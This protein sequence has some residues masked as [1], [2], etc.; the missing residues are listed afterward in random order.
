MTNRQRMLAAYRREQP[1]QVPVSPELWYD[2]P[3]EIDPDCTWQD[4]CLGRYPLWRAQ[5]AAHRYFGSAAWL[6]AAPAGQPTR[7]EITST[8][9][10]TPEGDLEVRCSGACGSGA[11]RWRV[12]SNAAFQDWM[13]E[14]PVKDLHRD[15]AAFETLF[16]PDPAAMDMTE[17]KAAL[18]GVGEDGVVTAYAGSLFFSFVAAHLEGGPAAAILAM[19]DNPSFFEGFQRRYVGWIAAVAERIIEECAPEVLMLDNGYSTASIIRPA[20]YEKWDLPVVR[21]VCEAAHGRGGLLHLHQ[22][23]R[24]AA[25]MDMIASAGVDLVDPFERPPSGDTPDLG[26]VKRAYGGRLAIRGNLHAHKTLLRGTPEDVEREVRECIAAAAAGGG[27]ILA[28]GDGV[29]AGTP[30]EN[31]FRMVEAGRKYGRY[32]QG[33]E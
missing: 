11:L 33:L 4:V 17:V 22:H 16:L 32:G 24:C 12:R 29:I 25:L 10:F 15:F 20:M 6:F 28:S 31:I 23:G 13:V 18:A 5:L 19:A 21:A 8:H 14:R 2:I 7:G 1:D 27:F 9:R 3:V 26:A 30:H